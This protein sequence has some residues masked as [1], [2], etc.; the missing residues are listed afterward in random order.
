VASRADIFTC[1]SYHSSAFEIVNGGSGRMSSN[2]MSNRRLLVRRIHRAPR[3][4]ARASRPGVRQQRRLQLRFL[5]IYKTVER[6]SPPTPEEMATT[7]KLIEEEMKAGWL[8]S[9]EGCLP[10]SLGARVRRSDGRVTVTDGSF[11]EAKEVIGGFAILKEHEARR[12]RAGQKVP[13]GYGPRRVRV[14]PAL[15]AGCGFELREQCG[16]R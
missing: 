12:D 14:A 10:T 1:K 3:L 5:S 8:L 11:T 13:P 6:T 9:T 16:A 4:Q 2:F 15:R 7:G